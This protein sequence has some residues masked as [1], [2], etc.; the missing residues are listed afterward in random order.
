MTENI[1]TTEDHIIIDGAEFPFYFYED[2]CVLNKPNNAIIKELCI[3]NSINGI[4]VNVIEFDF[5][6]GY[7]IGF[8]TIKICENNR[9]FAVVD[10]VL[11]SKDMERLILYPP[12]KKDEIYCM[13]VGVKIIEEESISNKYVKTMYLPNGLEKIVQY[14]MYVPELETIY[15]PRT[16]KKVY[17]KAFA[18]CKSLKTVFYEGTIEE[19]NTIDFTYFNEWLT[20]AEIHFNSNINYDG[21]IL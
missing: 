14:S 13:P 10:N 21:E 1:I 2:G 7:L 6:E 20:E 15:I 5:D 8:D 11:F 4:D 19:W 12:E 18:G 16:L 9:Y 3:P 17:L